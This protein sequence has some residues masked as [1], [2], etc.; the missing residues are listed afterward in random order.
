MVGSFNP[1][2]NAR[3]VS[4]R[5]AHVNTNAGIVRW[6]S[7]LLRTRPKAQDLNFIIAQFRNAM[8]Y[9]GVTD[10]E[11]DD[12]LLRKLLLK[13]DDTKRNFARNPSFDLWEAG[14]SFIQG[15][16][17][18]DLWKTRTAITGRT[19][20]RQTGFNGARYC[21][22][23]QRD[24][25][26]ANTS[27]LGVA[28]VMSPELAAQLAGETIIWSADIRKGADYSNATG[29]LNSRIISGTGVDET[30]DFSGTSGNF[31]TGN[32][33]STSFISG[34]LDTT[35]ARKT[36]GPYTIPADARE[37]ALILFWA[38]TGTAGAADYVDITNIKIEI[39]TRAT[40]F[41]FEPLAVT[42]GSALRLFQKSFNSGTAPAQNVG[43]GTGEHRFSA[44]MAGEAVNRHTVRLHVPMRSQP[45][46]TLFN[47]DS[48]N[49]Q[50]RDLTAGAGCTLSSAQN[51]S[52]RAFQIIC[53]GA[54]G[55]AVG[56]DL[57]VHFTADSRNF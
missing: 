20:S 12:T 57:G 9:F 43:S 5:P 1:S 17:I 52:D 18:A 23:M 2:D 27:F 32:V 19:Y 36:F 45:T 35:G 44:A 30:L 38:P 51:I 56:N 39:G 3:T 48:N 41:E 34:A 33:A 37:V 49:A 55:T 47:P 54:A 26:N 24:A 22:R 31:A 15:N 29:I 11:G 42:L 10:S 13:V 16:Y 7:D 53:T 8:S 25:A 50:V 28:H 4:E 14:T 46:V 40:A 21:L 6:W